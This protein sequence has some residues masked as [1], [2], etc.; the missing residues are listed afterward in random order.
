M[1]TQHSRWSRLAIAGAA[2]ILTAGCSVTVTPGGGSSA[3]VA[4]NSAPV[5]TATTGTSGTPHA[6][7]VPATGTAVPTAMPTGV[8]VPLDSFVV[9][10]TR[11]ATMS[12]TKVLGDDGSYDGLSL[13]AGCDG[14][15]DE[16]VLDIRGRELLQAALALRASTP[17]D[18]IAEVLILVDDEP[19]QNIRLDGTHPV[20]PLVPTVLA[21]TGK[22]KVTTRTK[23][24]R[25][26]CS[27]AEDSYVVWV[28]GYVH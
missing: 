7:T 22:Q 1:M 28:N 2:L 4:P 25:G 27:E 20:P 24:V 8:P 21:L 6:G 16:V 12:T 19:V 17:T 5:T 13:W 10:S 11:P 23:V 15:V 26:E 14:N 3:P 9:S 18:I